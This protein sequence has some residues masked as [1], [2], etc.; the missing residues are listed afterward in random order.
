MDDA[1]VDCISFNNTCCFV[2]FAGGALNILIIDSDNNDFE[3]VWKLSLS[4]VYDVQVVVPA[5][6]LIRPI[7]FAV[8]GVLVYSS[9]PMTVTSGFI[10]FKSVLI[11]KVSIVTG[12]ML[13]ITAIDVVCWTDWNAF[14]AVDVTNVDAIEPID[15]I[16]M[17]CAADDGNDVDM[18]EAAF[19]AYAKFEV[20]V[21][22]RRLVGNDAGV[23]GVT[24]FDDAVKMMLAVKVVADGKF[25]ANSFDETVFDGDV[26]LEDIGSD[27]TMDEAVIAFCVVNEK[28][29][30][31]EAMFG[32][33]VIL[34]VFKGEI[35]LNNVDVVVVGMIKVAD[36]SCEAVFVLVK[37]VIFDWSEPIADNKPVGST[38]PIEVKLNVVGV[39]LLILIIV[40]AET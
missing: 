3:E 26:R 15:K 10:K 23:G 14:V 17:F 7:A 38:K 25:D 11:T 4:P 29:I 22:D 8:S 6:C 5:A 9:E 40:S 2:I 12:F 34:G 16:W 39:T 32:K 37:L 24:S 20:N 21:W 27:A 31:V 33:F 18:A 13:S 1:V 35:W 36:E 28:N 19:A 30:L